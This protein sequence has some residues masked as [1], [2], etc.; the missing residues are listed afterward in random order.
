MKDKSAP[1]LRRVWR[2]WIRP[3]L[4][5]AIVLFSLRSSLADWNDVPTG[6]MEPAILPGE[7]IYVHFVR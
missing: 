2:G 1:F 5:T 4:I 7:R 3:L 6:S